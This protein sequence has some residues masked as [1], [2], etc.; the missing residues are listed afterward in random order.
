MGE[1]EFQTPR[2][3]LQMHVEPI[4]TEFER[5]SKNGIELNLSGYVLSCL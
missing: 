3:P 4:W 2:I 1:I 5:H